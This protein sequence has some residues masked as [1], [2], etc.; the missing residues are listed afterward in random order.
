MSQFKTYDKFAPSY[1][2]SSLSVQTSEDLLERAAPYL[3]SELEEPPIRA[4]LLRHKIISVNNCLRLLS[5]I[6]V[7]IYL[8]C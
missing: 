6:R 3:L 8:F 1:S 5:E 4:A 7:S 2:N